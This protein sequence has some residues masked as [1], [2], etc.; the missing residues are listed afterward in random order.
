MVVMA[1]VKYLLW[2]KFNKQSKTLESLLKHSVRYFFQLPFLALTYFAFATEDDISQA[3]AAVFCLYCVFAVA[4]YMYLS[5]K[6]RYKPFWFKN[7][8]IL[9]KED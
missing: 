6:Y 1:G 4:I 7:K 8:K 5:G 3:L 2:T 9:K